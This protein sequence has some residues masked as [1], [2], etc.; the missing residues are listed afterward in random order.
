MESGVGPRQPGV[1]ALL[2]AALSLVPKPEGEGPWG[3]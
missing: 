1:V 2:L 3:P